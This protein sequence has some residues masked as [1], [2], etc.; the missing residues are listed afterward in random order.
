MDYFNLK[1]TI[2]LLKYN[3]FITVL[4]EAKKFSLCSVD[5]N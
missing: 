2:G 1:E 5:I 3:I 4:I